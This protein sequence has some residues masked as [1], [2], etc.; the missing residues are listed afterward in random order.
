MHLVQFMAFGLSLVAASP[1]VPKVKV[2]DECKAVDIVVD[3]L[4]LNKATPFCSSFLSVKTSTATAYAT[5]TSTSTQ[6][7]QGP[8]I[9]STDYLAPV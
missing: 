6:Q 8:T 7:V 1:V 5:V 4:K 3:V 2:I 9:T